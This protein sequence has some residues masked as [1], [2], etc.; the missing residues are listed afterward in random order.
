MLE[1]NPSQF[2]FI[3]LKSHMDY[4][5]CPGAEPGTSDSRRLLTACLSYGPL[6]PRASGLYSADCRGGLP[7][8]MRVSP[9]ECHD[10]WRSDLISSVL[11]YPSIM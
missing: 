7:R 8:L 6:T 11:H 5:D 10:H 3:H 4:I 9:D 1:E 2:H